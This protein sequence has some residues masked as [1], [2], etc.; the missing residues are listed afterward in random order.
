MATQTKLPP[1]FKIK[2]FRPEGQQ[3]V[4]ST[5]VEVGT[6]A[7]ETTIRFCDLKPAISPE[8]LEKIAKEGSIEIPVI[9]EVVLP[10]HVAN[11]L[12][13]VLQ[14]QLQNQ[15]K[16]NKEEKDTEEKK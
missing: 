5:F 4:Y 13:N 10:P 2:T 11:I 12:A 8:E 9:T 1:D 6:N 3:R 16:I 14:T 7:N 15:I